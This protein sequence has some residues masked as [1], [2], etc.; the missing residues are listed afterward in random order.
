MNSFFVPQLGSQVYAMGGM[1]TH[2]NLLADAPGEYRGF[3]ANF[4]GDGF[5]DM[6]FVVQAMPTENFLGWVGQASGS[7]TALDAAAYAALAK[8]TMAVAPTTYRSVAPDLFDHIVQETASGRP[9]LADAAWCWPVQL[10][11]E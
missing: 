6:R 3:S 4:S 5:A 2:L 9:G 11:G 8:P 10:T 1:T 7:A